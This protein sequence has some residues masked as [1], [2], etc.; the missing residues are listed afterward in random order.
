MF[1]RITQV[2][3][4]K[5]DSIRVRA[6]CPLPIIRF[7]YIK[8]ASKYQCFNLPSIKLLSNALKHGIFSNSFLDLRQLHTMKL[9]LW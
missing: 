3:Q 1:T 2:Q 8:P 6:S 7:V 5:S 4:Q 9:D